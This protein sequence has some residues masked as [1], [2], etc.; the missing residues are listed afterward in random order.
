MDSCPEQSKVLVDS[1][2]NSLIG[3]GGLNWFFADFDDIINNGAGPKIH[4]S[5]DP[6]LMPA[7]QVE[8]FIAVVPNSFA[9]PTFGKSD[10]IRPP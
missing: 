7:H 4:G 1:S 10:P 8:C 9:I 2:P 5:A 3:G 6:R